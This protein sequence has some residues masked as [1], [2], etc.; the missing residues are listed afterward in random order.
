MKKW[1]KVTERTRRRKMRNRRKIRGTPDRPRLSVYRSN[2]YIYAQL[3]DDESGQTLAASSSL[4]LVRADGLTAKY[5]GN[6][7]AAKQVGLDIAEKAK[8]KGLTAVRL[9]RGPYKYHGRVQ[10]L[11][12]GARE[13]GLVF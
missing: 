11:A 10:A 2:R 7:E 5:S 12:D 6:R 8:D 13:G 3:I 9:D 4:A 1:K